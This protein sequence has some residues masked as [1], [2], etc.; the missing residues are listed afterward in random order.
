VMVVSIYIYEVIRVLGS[1]GRGG[2][3]AGML[4]RGRAWQSWR[5][6]GQ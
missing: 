4:R 1:P 2:S 3:M 5:V 6:A